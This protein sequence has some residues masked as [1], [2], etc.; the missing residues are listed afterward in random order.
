MRFIFSAV[1]CILLALFPAF[2]QS[3][4]GT[5]EQSVSAMENYRLGRELE[6]LSRI[7]EANT[8]Y[9]EA[10][11]QCLAEVYPLQRGYPPMPC[12]SVRQYRLAHYLYGFN[13][14][15]AAAKKI[16]RSHNMGGKGS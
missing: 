11:R 4:G 7:N 8:H 6:N 2:A 9:N 15:I 5:E 16:F 1:I 13:M 14:D 3:P 10:I 12:R